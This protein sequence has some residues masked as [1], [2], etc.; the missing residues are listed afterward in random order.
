V[1]ACGLPTR[2]RNFFCANFRT[3]GV[4]AVTLGVIKSG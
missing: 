1:M 2:R 4:S 3:Q